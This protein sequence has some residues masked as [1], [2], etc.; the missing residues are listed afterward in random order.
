M[1]K[2]KTTDI[3]DGFDLIEYP[4]EF[5]FKAMCLAN[6]GA[7]AQLT[8]LIT[9]L[10]SEKN[11]L[12][13]SSKLSKTSKYESVSLTVL[14]RSRDELEAIYKSLAANPSVVMTL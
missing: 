5:V 14:L 12:G 1:N 11:L 7:Q 4:H 6:Q 8:E 10:V 3:K 2:D 13:V 9:G